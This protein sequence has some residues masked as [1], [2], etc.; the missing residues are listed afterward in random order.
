MNLF[1]TK[2]L[3]KREQKKIVL[4]MREECSKQKWIELHERYM[5]YEKMLKPSMKVNLDVV[6][7]VVGSLLS[8]VLI[9]YFDKSGLLLR[10]K[11]AISFI[12]RLRT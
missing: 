9:A 3:I 8:A 10:K 4:K 5:I 7:T 11:E 1:S 2:T 6:I 12:N